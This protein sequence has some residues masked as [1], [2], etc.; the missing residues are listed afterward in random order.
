MDPFIAIALCFYMFLG[1]IRVSLFYEN[2][3]MKKKRTKK[4]IARFKLILPL[5]FITY[6]VILIF[7]VF[8]FWKKFTLC[9]IG[10]LKEAFRRE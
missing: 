2:F 7:D 5:I 6:P 3:M 10:L 9:V 1:V 8:M 4:E